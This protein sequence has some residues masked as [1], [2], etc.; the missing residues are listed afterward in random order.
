MDTWTHRDNDAKRHR[1]MRGLAAWRHRV[2]ENLGIE[3][4]RQS[5]IEA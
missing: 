3:A 1:G 4:K 2:M 5:G